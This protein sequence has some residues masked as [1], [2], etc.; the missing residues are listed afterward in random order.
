MM[1]LFRLGIY[2]RLRRMCKRMTHHITIS[3]VVLMRE[4]RALLDSG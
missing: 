4:L 3:N 1:G 2:H